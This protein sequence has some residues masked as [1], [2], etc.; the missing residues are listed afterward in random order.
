V[1]DAQPVGDPWAEALDHHVGGGDEASRDRPIV[2][3]GQ[4]EGDAALAPLE[5]CVHRIDP[6]GPARRVDPD[7][8][9]AEVRQDHGDRG[10]GQPMAEVDDPDTLERSIHWVPHLSL[11]RHDRFR[12]GRGSVGHRKILA[13]SATAPP[14]GPAE[15]PC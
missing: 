4:I 7:D 14:Q 10:A 2:V 1:A 11:G 3:V 5:E 13:Q 8:I 12:S 15:P 9:R 6:P